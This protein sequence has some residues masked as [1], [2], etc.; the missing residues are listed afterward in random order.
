MGTAGVYGGSGTQPWAAVRDSFDE[1]PASASGDAPDVSSPSSDAD[2]AEPASP[3]DDLAGLLADALAIDDPALLQPTQPR[4]IPSLLPRTGSGGVGGG[5]RAGRITGESAG[6]GRTGS[7]SR[8]S[9][10]AGAARG[11]AAIGGAY[12]LR[13]GDR[14]ALAELG[15]DLDQLRSLGPRSQ[16]AHILDTVLGEGG[17]PDEAALRAAAAEQLKA[18]IMQPDPPAEGDSLRGFIAAFV[19]QL[20]L[21]ELRS[22][23]AS[24]DLDVV[25]ATRKEGRLRRYL[26]TRVR[27]L[28]VPTA[29]RLSIAAFG[30]HADRLVREAINLLRSR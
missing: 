1:L 21:V 13:A 8:R 15:L 29:G 25:T 22:Q 14:A 19:F 26:E 5:G 18:I 24:G 17:H 4:T 9:V 27:H 2:G 16:S 6:S 10:T 12:A 7:G 30:T 28:A 11:G 20:A 3:V 23:L